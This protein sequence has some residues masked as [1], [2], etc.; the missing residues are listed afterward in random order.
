[1]RDE[2]EE[3]RGPVDPKSE[4]SPA[5]GIALKDLVGFAFSTLALIVSLLTFYMSNIRVD[6]RAFARIAAIRVAFNPPAD[7]GESNDFVVVQIAFLNPGNR[8]AVVL[9]ALYSLGGT[10]DLLKG[11]E[12][13]EPVETDSGVLPLLLTPGHTRLVEFRIPVKRIVVGY[14]QGEP[15]DDDFLALKRRLYCGLVFTSLDSGGVVYSTWAGAQCSILSSRT[16][17]DTDVSEIESPFPLIPLFYVPTVGAP[18]VARPVSPWWRRAVASV[19]ALDILVALAVVAV[20]LA[21]GALLRRGYRAARPGPAP[22]DRP[23]PA[24]N[25]ATPP[26]PAVVDGDA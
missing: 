12:I 14:G 20:I 17:I 13:Q 4:T 19:T 2:Q 21:S 9:R 8:D 18:L 5:S 3:K 26:A 24:S 10:K 6:D 7:K 16:G 22:A 1:M 11:S 25:A 15:D 23:P